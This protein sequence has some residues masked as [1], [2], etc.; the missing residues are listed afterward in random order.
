MQGKK[1]SSMWKLGIA[2][3]VV[4]VLLAILL[5]YLTLFFILPGS[6]EALSTACMP[7]KGYMCRNPILH[8]NKYTVVLGQQTGLNWSNAS[9]I[10]VPSGVS[11]PGSNGISCNSLYSNTITSGLSCATPSSTNLT[12][13]ES[14]T[15]NF[16]FSSPSQ[17][18]Q[19]YDGTIY[20]EYETPVKNFPSGEV[21][22]VQIA[23]V[24]LKAA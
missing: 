8:A 20:A 3:I 10:W 16:V 7:L 21:Y 12:N 23:Y 2:T 24:S 4:L 6:G 9:F 15:E 17:A 13:G 11:G 18:G 22:I 1:S 19:S 14:V 5:Y